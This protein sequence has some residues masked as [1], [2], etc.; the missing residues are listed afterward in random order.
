M[1]SNKQYSVKLYIDITIS[2]PWA[3]SNCVLSIS[4]MQLVNVAHFLNI[5]FD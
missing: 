3:S 4:L 1:Y 2:M 5:T